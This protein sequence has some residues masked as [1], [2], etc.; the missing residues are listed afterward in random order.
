MDTTGRRGNPSQLETDVAE[1][2]GT[3]TPWRVVATDHSYMRH[4]DDD[5]DLGVNRKR[6]C[7]FLLVIVVT[8]VAYRTVFEISP[9][10]A[11][12]WLVFFPTRPL[13][14]SPLRGNTSAFLD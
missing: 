12:K 6:M 11:R 3:W 10:K 2:G 4:D 1:C 14:D 7:N 5:D 13:F 9:H 8:L